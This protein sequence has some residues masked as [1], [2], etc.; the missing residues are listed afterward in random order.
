[1]QYWLREPCPDFRYHRCAMSEFIS[2]IIPVLNEAPQLGAALEALQYLR[3]RGHELIVADGGSR[4]GSVTIAR[5]LADRV[6]MSGTGRALQMNAGAGYA[7]HEVLLFLHVD[8]RLPDNADQLILQALG[9]PDSG[10]GCFAI[11][12]R[13]GQPF[14]RLLAPLINWQR[15]LC[16]SATGD[17]ALFVRRTLFEKV[18]AFD[19]LPLLED[20]AMGNKLRRHARP[21]RIATPAETH[22]RRW[23][24][25][26]MLR[27][28]L[29]MWWLRT[30]L[31]LGTPPAKLLARHY[32]Q[33]PP[34]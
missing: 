19:G 21:G 26:G 15:A 9:S 6:V 13:G 18:G 30:G 10:W 3:G 2:I 31:W 32:R 34:S 12:L 24:R 28:M 8:T 29:L 20:I 23:Q 17:Q 25:D 1:M 16:G 11:R 22:S 7:R 33:E 5:R 27:T 4:D 14:L